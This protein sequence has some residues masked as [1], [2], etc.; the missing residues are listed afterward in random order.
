MPKEE[1]ARATATPAGDPAKVEERDA[2]QPNRAKAPEVEVEEESAPD[3]AGDADTTADTG[4]DGDD[5]GAESED[6]ANTS[7]DAPVDPVTE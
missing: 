5:D 3:S 2:T 6:G 1:E 4:G 7:D